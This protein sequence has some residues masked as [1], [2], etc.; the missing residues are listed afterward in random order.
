MQASSPNDTDMNEEGDSGN[1][2]ENKGQNMRRLLQSNSIF[3]ESIKNKTSQSLKWHGIK[4]HFD[5]E[6]YFLSNLKHKYIV[7]V[8]ESGSD[9][10]IPL[11]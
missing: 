8:L 9:A 4:R 5:N 7:K 2:N 6:L 11:V 10:N 1:F 3:D